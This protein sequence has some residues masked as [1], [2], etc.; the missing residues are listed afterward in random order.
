[1]L[2]FKMQNFEVWNIFKIFL[3]NNGLGQILSR[4]IKW[5]SH[6]LCHSRPT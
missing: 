1:M 6:E 5:I 3:R 2:H 4:Y